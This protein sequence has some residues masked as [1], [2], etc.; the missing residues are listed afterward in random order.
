ME[1]PGVIGRMPILEPGT[2]FDYKRCGGGGVPVHLCVTIVCIC[3]YVRLCVCVI[4]SFLPCRSM[5]S[6]SGRYSFRDSD[7]NELF[8]AEVAPFAVYS[9]PT[10]LQPNDAKD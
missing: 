9:L 2:D 3:A 10:D 5:T 6:M 4:C 7:T 8:T 1:G